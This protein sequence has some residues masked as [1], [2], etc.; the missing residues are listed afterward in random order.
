MGQS[1]EGAALYQPR[2]E[3]PLSRANEIMDAQP[4]VTLENIM[5][6]VSVQWFLGERPTQPLPWV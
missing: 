2:E 1:P 4:W 3:R 6:S 5:L